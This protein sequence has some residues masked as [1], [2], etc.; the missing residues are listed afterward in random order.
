[1]IAQMVQDCID[2]D[3]GNAADHRDKIQEEME[4]M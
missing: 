4:D 2:E 3:F 1:M